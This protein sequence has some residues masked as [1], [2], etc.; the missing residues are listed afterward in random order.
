[1]IG[2]FVYRDWSLDETSVMWFGV[3]NGVQ[4]SLIR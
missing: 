4:Q 3:W 1:M 2:A